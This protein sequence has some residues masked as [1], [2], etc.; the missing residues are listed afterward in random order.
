M[1]VSKSSILFLPKLM[2]S[3]ILQCQASNFSYRSNIRNLLV[4]SFHPSS[5]LVSSKY[6]S[7][8]NFDRKISPFLFM[9]SIGLKIIVVVSMYRCTADPNILV[10][11]LT[12]IQYVFFC[13]FRCQNFHPS[14]V[15][16]SLV[17]G[18]G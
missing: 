11:S 14:L 7:A 15:F 18:I 13:L 8:V 1:I 6:P 16:P 5:I 2:M 12:L 9:V 10:D 3:Y 17:V 4:S